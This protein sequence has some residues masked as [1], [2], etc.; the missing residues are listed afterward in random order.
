MT[1]TKW[2]NAKTNV[3][4]FFGGLVDQYGYDLRSL[5]FGARESQLKRF[6][7]IAQYL[8]DTEFS[9]LD[10]SKSSIVALT[11]RHR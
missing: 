4:S 9:L 1:T 5:D 6:E 10:D 11:L 8:P 3:T 2:N 7:V